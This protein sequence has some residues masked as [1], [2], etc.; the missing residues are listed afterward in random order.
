MLVLISDL[1][2]NDGTTGAVLRPGAFSLFAER[3]QELA[4]AASWRN[5]GSYRPIERIDLV[6][7]GDIL[8][9]LRST[10]WNGR[11]SVRP[12]ANPHSPELFNQIARTTADILAQN[13]EGLAVL[14]SLSREGRICVP[15]MLR[16]SRPAGDAEGQPVPVR[17]WYMVG[18][19]DWFYHL[20]G[21]EYTTLRQSLVEQLGLANRPDRPFPH[22]MT[23]S[24]ELFQT[25]RRHRVAARHGDV[26]DPLSFDGDRDC[27]SL[28]DALV[29]DLV[30]RFYSEV[31]ASLA[32][33]LPQTTVLGMREL[34]F[35]R[36]LAWVPV[37]IE[38]LLER[39]CP[40]PA[41]RKR[42]RSL[43]DRLA[44]E[45]LA[46]D[47]V[48]HC[49]A[50]GPPELIDGLAR[51]MKFNKRPAVGWAGATAR[52]LEKLRGAPGPS[53]TTHAL[54]EPDFRNRRARHIVYGHSH[55]AELVPLDASYTEGHT[56]DQVYFNAGTWRRV[57]GPTLLALGEHEFVASDVM[58]YLAFFQ[59]DE[60]KGRPYETWSGAL[61]HTPTRMTVHRIDAGRLHHAADHVPTPG[62]PTRAPHFATLPGKSAG[63]TARRGP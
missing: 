60:R 32:G 11:P 29:I 1:H 46:S 40:A 26:Y 16:S 19:C 57:D 34:S 37:W 48:R 8:D 14:R 42:V 2:L 55:A 18:N 43:W 24:D 39:T 31:E 10:R 22:D 4:L 63:I 44:D 27:A 21:P 23:E 41:V 45:L 47:F 6:L 58:T 20:P 49:G 30:G 59:G 50:E 15:P 61:G 53:Y 56:Q 5:D 3:L 7:L 13:E 9:P 35:V 62:L 12:W 51:A 36:P 33:E 52:W 28:S 54:V 25:L 17:T 38:G